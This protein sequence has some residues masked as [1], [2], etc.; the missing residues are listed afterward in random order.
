MNAGTVCRV[1]DLSTAP[2]AAF[3][4]RAS[5]PLPPH[6]EEP[7][8]AVDL[9]AERGRAGTL[10]DH[11]AAAG[12]Q[13]GPVDVAVD[14]GTEVRVRCRADRD[15]LGLEAVGQRD[16]GRARGTMSSTRGGGTGHDRE[17]GRGDERENTSGH[18]QFLPGGFGLSSPCT[19]A[20]A[21]EFNLHT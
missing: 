6:D 12:A 20:M 2:V 8:A 15:S 16:G 14:P 13:A 5:P 3:S 1:Y 4:T 21:T 19:P 11:L 10:A 18:E 7:A 9:E 17:C